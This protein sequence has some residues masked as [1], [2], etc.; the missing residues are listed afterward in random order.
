MRFGLVKNLAPAPSIPSRKGVAKSRAN[1]AVAQHGRELDASAEHGRAPVDRGQLLTS[2]RDERGARTPGAR[3][4]VRGRGRVRGGGVAQR[5]LDHAAV[6]ILADLREHA[7]ELCR[8]LLVEI[9]IARDLREGR[10]TTKVDHAGGK[11]RNVCEMRRAGSSAID[12]L[13]GLYG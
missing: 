5:R 3:R 7:L 6:A 11:N 12:W 8:G 10:P 9:K 2:R 4:R 1:L 13:V